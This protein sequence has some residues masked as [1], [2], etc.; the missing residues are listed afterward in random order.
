[1]TFS[2]QLRWFIKFHKHHDT[3]LGIIV[4]IIFVLTFIG[5]RMFVGEYSN[6]EVGIVEPMANDR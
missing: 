3:T 2:F 4:D 5:V 6:D 1:M